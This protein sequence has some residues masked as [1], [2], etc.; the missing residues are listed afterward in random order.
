[1]TAPPGWVFGEDQVYSSNEVTWE[2]AFV[3]RERAQQTEAERRYRARR[4]GE[5]VA[6]RQE[7]DGATPVRDRWQEHVDWDDPA[8]VEWY[9]RK[10]RAWGR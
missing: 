10:R 3:P 5:S 9:G 6:L 8:L 2:E 4:R 1:M 7:P